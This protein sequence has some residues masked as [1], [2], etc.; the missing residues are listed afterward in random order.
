METHYQKTVDLTKLSYDNDGHVLP[1]GSMKKHII[2]IR[3]AHKSG[4]PKIYTEIKNKKIITHNYGHSGVGYSIL[5]GSVEKSIE[6]FEKFRIDNNKSHTDEITVIGIGCMG[7]TTALTLY[8]RGYKNIKLIGE[9]GV[10]PSYDAG[11]LIEF[12]LSTI[13]NQENVNYINNLF[14]HSF[15]EYR[16]IAQGGHKYIKN[17]VKE[18]DYYT[19]FFQEGAG[20]S[21]LANIGLIPQVKHVRLK[22]GDCESRELWHFK[23]YHVVTTVFMNELTY[24]LKKLGINI[25]H[26][27]I[28]SFDE[29]KSDMIFNCTG[30][31][32]RELNNDKDCYPICGHG[33][34]LSDDS[35]KNHGY[36][37]R[38]SEVSEFNG[39]K[40]GG[41]LYFMPKDSGFIGGSYMK[42]YDGSNEKVNKEVIT[43]MIERSKFIFNGMRPKF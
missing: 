34:I 14:K 40:I 15:L 1:K 27:I 29:I 41:S 19:D 17:G 5:F 24:S 30:L 26:K 9:K 36:I 22:L 43:N 4:L 11:G 32:S 13:Y 8:L 12:S 2:C 38:L 10:G 16:K 39:H 18:V 3:P 28:N 31:G 20:L 6:N 21:Y 23:T 33:V 25:E 42:D 7:L 35:Y 37:L